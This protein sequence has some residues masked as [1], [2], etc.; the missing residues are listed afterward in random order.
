MKP[1]IHHFYHVY[2]DGNWL[3]IVEDH[4]QALQKYGL[5]DNLASFNVGIVGS[6]QNVDTFI[7]FL[8]ECDLN[9]KI[10][11]TNTDGWEQVTLHPLWETSN[12]EENCYF[13]YAHTK[14]AVNSYDITSAWRRGMTRHLI[15]EWKKCVD[16]LDSGYSTVGCHLQPGRPDQPFPFWGGN[17]WW[18]TSKH[19]QSLGRCPE[20][21]R[22]DA[23]AWIGTCHQTPIYKPYDVFPVAIGSESEPY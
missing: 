21:T 1:L 10:T 13:V 23:E 8:R 18:A 17:Y 2:V 19:I 7:E 9:F 20:F 6:D 12:L 14:G 16:A 3:E 22:Y 15:V 11:A 5:Y 4:L